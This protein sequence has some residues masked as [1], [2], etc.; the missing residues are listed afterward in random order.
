V[1]AP[2][3]GQL[4]AFAAEMGENKT[5]GTR[6][7][8]IDV[9]DRYKIVAQID[10]FYVTRVVSGQMA[11]FTL[12]GNE[13]RATVS[14]VYPE[15]QNGTFNV[16]LVFEGSTPADMRRGQTLQ[17]NLTLGNPVQSLLLPVGGFI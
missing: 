6:L 17:M 8:Q 10:E 9:A 13:Y 3:S 7:G 4:T 11:R 5:R 15:I 14:K 16:D 2:I 12:S 1:R